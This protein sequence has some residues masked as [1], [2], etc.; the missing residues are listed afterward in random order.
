VI[1]GI[2]DGYSTVFRDTFAVALLEKKVDLKTVSVLSGHTSIK[3]T[4]KHYAP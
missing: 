3:A 4:E 1:A 2:K